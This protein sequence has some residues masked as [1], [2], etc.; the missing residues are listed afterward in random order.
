[1][2]K[3]TILLV[4]FVGLVFADIESASIPF[5]P[6]RQVVKDLHVRCGAS[7]AASDAVEFPAVP[8]KEGMSVVLKLNQRI[9]GDLNSGWNRYCGIEIN[10]TD[11]GAVTR[12]NYPRLLLRGPVMHTSHP[13][14]QEVPYWL[15]SA[16]PYLLCM[17]GPADD[18]HLD[19]RILDRQYGYDFYLVVDDLVNKLIVGADDRVESNEPNRIRF[20]NGLFKHIVDTSLYIREATI[21]YVPTDRLNELSGVTMREFKPIA[22]PAAVVKGDGFA[23]NVS[24]T[25]GMELVVGEGRIY[26][27]SQFS[28]PRQPAMKFNTFGVDGVSGEPG[29]SANVDA[30][31]RI[32]FKTPTLEIR[33][34]LRPC[35]HFIRV[36]DSIANVSKA[37]VG[38]VWRH[39]AFFSGDMPAVWRLAG[40]SASNSSNPF[41]AMNPTLYM[42]DNKSCGVGVIAED[43]VSRNLITLQTESNAVVLG[44]KGVGIQ[45]GKSLTLEWTIYPLKPGAMDYFD[46]INKV[47]EDWGVNNTIPGPFLFSLSEKP[48]LNLQFGF[49]NKWHNYSDG[50]KLTDEQFVEVLKSTAEP[51]R[52]KFPGIKLLGKVETNLVPFRVAQYEWSK[53]LPMT[54]GDRK[55]PK[56]KYAQYLPPELSQKLA[57][58]SPYRDSMLWNDKGGVM[59]DN[60]YTYDNYDTINLMVQ[61]ETGNARYRKFMEQIELIMDKGG[62]NGLYID[63]FNPGPR[64]GIDYSKWDGVSV[65]L[66]KAGNIVSKFY[67]YTLTGAE[68]RRDIIRRIVVEKGGI[69][70]TNGH[71]VTRE[72]QNSGRLSFV[73]MENDSINPMEFLTKK[74]PETSWT[75]L[76]HL[77]SPISLNLRPQRY[78]GGLPAGGPDYRAQVLTKGFILALRNAT[79]PYYYSSDIPLEGPTAGSY[80]ITNWF[81]PFTPV[82]IGEGVMVGRER[83]IVC[84]SGTYTVKG[85]KRPKVARFNCYGRP[86]E[87]P[88]E[89]TG[90]PGAWNVKV[91]LDD[92]N[93]IAAIVVAD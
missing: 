88:F 44:C 63:Q 68:G 89:I 46:F 26:F 82:R 65:A 84:M 19:N 21:G 24:Q 49:I 9:V 47:R 73:E 70:F 6:Y 15:V 50:W 35:G 28:Y 64:D 11:V 42:S 8:A 75:V 45:A 33:R 39:S 30:E 76:G 85:A 93:E 78:L 5:T 66:D 61:V 1:M 74:P 62:L 38:L 36:I 3:V 87:A 52:A 23:M 18:D 59:I 25:G 67:N 58:V 32:T 37:D 71:P 2:K 4:L 41:A 83:T 27:E 51:L 81:M 60:W 43:N 77:A 54:R 7:V 80:E 29:I 10:G 20:F 57:E 17:F 53:E 69:A 79:I 31:G 48:G 13:K 90:K 56:T 22:N 92:W 86:V 14:E 16:H 91:A 12:A 34:T 55:N 40:V 72:E